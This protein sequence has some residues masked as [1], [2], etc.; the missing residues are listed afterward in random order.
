MKEIKLAILGGGSSYTPELLDGVA[1]RYLEG[2][3]H[4]KE[5]VMVDI[6]EGRDRMETVASF[7]RRM[8]SK[9]GMPCS[10]TTTVNRREAF[11]GASFVISQVRVGG[12]LSRRKDEHIPL[13]HGVIGQ[14]TTGAGGFA[15]ALRTIPVSLEF[16]RE[17]Q[18]RCPDAWLLNFSNPSGLVTEALIRYSDTKTFGLCNVPIGIRMGVAKAL[19]VQPS[20]VSMD[21][22]GLN[23]LSFVTGIWVGDHDATVTIFDSPLFDE[24]L[25][26][27]KYGARMGRFLK[28]LRVIPA[29]YLSYYWCTERALREQLDDLSG[30]KGSRADE[31]MR[32]ERDLFQMY[33]KPENADLPEALKKRGGAYYSDVALN[34]ISAIVNNRPVVEAL[35]VVNRGSVPGISAGSV[36]E[37]SCMVDAR[38]PH[39]LA[40]KPLPPEVMGLV[41]QVKAYESLTVEAAVTG[42]IEKAFFALLNHPLIPGADTA[43]ALLKDI[44]EANKD[45]LPRFAGKA[46]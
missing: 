12:M 42:D 13:K 20:Q 45:Y 6:P 25:K 40:Q 44:L 36:V 8:L 32:I 34:S 46:F 1:K 24:Y 41:Q 35:N 9:R 29:S 27:E 4:A 31:V 11:D 3:F 23:H 43:Q 18:D 28:R 16:A 22:S 33:A 21:V 15:N 17:M 38:G 10:L 39:P 26:I 30:E 14:E 2:E 37:V 19:G 7:A 5:I